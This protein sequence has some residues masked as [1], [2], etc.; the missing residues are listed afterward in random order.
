MYHANDYSLNMERNHMPSVCNIEGTSSQDTRK[1]MQSVCN[2]EGT[3]GETT[4]VCTKPP[5][6]Y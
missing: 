3:K 1:E 4:K 5:T 6:T 2:I